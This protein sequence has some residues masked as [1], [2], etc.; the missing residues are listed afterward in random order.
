MKALVRLT[1]LQRSRK[2]CVGGEGG[3]GEGGRGRE[4]STVLDICRILTELALLPLI[5][6]SRNP[7]HSKALTLSLTWALLFISDHGP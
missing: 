3:S 1:K 2:V 4:I 6:L 5:V 7:C